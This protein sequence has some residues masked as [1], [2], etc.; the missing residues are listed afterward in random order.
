MHTGKHC[1]MHFLFWVVWN[2]V[3]YRYCFLAL[4]WYMQLGRS[5]K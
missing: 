4:L 3:I 2:M 5:K 1:E